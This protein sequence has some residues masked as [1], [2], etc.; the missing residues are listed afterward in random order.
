MMNRKTIIAVTITVISL[1]AVAAMAQGYGR[2]A[3]HG[4]G[5]GQGREGRFE[6]MV[7]HLDLTEVQQEAITN[8]HEETREANEALTRD[9]LVLENELEGELLK[10]EPS[11]NKVLD[12]NKKLGALRT[13]RQAN[14]LKAR[15]A[16]RKQLTPEQQDQMLTFRSRGGRG[17]RQ[18]CD[19]HGLHKGH[20]EGQRMHR[21]HDAD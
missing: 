9:R 1:A 14:R 15:L 16:V 21:G 5:M 3:G 13:E 19:G 4:R 12:L 18:G 8:I 20:G 17:G 7:E 10:E 11:E 2:G 6:M